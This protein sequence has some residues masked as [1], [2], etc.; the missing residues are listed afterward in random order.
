MNLL[1][2]EKLSKKF[3]GI[4]ILNQIS[5]DLEPG[6]SMAI[7]GRSGSGKSTLL[8]MLAG[9]DS[10][11]DGTI[12][13]QNHDIT[14]LSEPELAKVRGQNMGFVFQTFRLIEALTALENVCLPLELQ[15]QAH[16]VDIA[17]EWL[18]KLG[19]KDKANQFPYT[20]SGGEQQRIAIA[21]ALVHKPALILADEPTGN[22]DHKTSEEVV[23]LLCS[24]ASQTNTALIVATHDHDLAKRTRKTF[25]LFQGKLRQI[26]L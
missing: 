14:T 12:T 11:D 21:R 15:Q 3:D 17:Y 23:Q 10:P 18:E 19:L 2:V 9:L 5:F 6:D 1:K 24:L 25:E 16:A 22:L 13:F 8:H 26:S 7:M 4:P 20:L